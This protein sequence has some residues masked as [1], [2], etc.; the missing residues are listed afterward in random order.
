MKLNTIKDIW[1]SDFVNMGPIRLRQPLPTQQLDMVDPF[2]LLHHY[3]PYE[4]NEKSNPFDLGPHPHRGFEPITFLVQ[5]EQLHRD[6][7]GNES[8]V[9]AGDVQWTTAGRGIIHAEGPTK[10][11]VKKGGTIEGIQLWLNLPAEKKMMEANYQHS[12]YEDFRVA[13]SDDKKVETRIVAGEL[14][15]TY[16]IIATQTPVNAF[17]IEA[18]VNGSESITFS[19]LH[20]GLLYLLKGKVKVNGATILE[21]DKNQ[22][23]QFNQDGEGFSIE[24]EDNSLLLFLSGEPFN[25]PVKTYGPYVMNTQTELMEAMRDYQMGKMG[26]LTPN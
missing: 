14:N 26:F 15:Q 18:K 8:T 13:T 7:L 12:K 9:K 22:M 25:E 16:G 24:A 2:I 19:H 21:L 11:F 6:S 20:Q 10:D 17:M 3:G 1:R 5:G 23:I 4:I